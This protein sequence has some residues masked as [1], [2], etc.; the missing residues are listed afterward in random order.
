MEEQAQSTEEDQRLYKA[1]LIGF[2]FRLLSIG[3]HSLFCK[4]YMIILN[5]FLAAG[6][7]A[8]NL[9]SNIY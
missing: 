3:S 6:K 1:F 9:N 4:A 5:Y 8:Y 2:T 7:L